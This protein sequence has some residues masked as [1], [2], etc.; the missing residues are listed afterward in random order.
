VFIGGNPLTYTS[1][2]KGRYS[3][4]RR[5]KFDGNWS[6]ENSSK[7]RKSNNLKNLIGRKLSKNLK[8]L[9]IK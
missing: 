2:E 9:V 6:G 5:G 3:E 1:K 8:E 7:T 4:V